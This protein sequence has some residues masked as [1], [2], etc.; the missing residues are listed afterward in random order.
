MIKGEVD[1]RINQNGIGVKFTKLIRSK[2]VQKRH[3]Y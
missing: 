3:M 1:V 2:K